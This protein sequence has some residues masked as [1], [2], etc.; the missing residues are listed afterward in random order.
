MRN[1][2]KIKKY[3]NKWMEGLILI[4]GVSLIFLLPPGEEIT[5][6]KVL[7][8]LIL[9]AF[10]V[11]IL[12][13]YFGKFIRKKI[14]LLF[15]LLISIV[16]MGK[17]IILIPSVSNYFIPIAFFSILTSFLFS[18]LPLSILGTLLVSI[19]LSINAGS[20]EI[21]PVL[22]IG[23]L[24]GTYSTSSIHQ[25]T[26]LTRAG[27]YVGMANVC[28]ISGMSFI[29]GYSFLSTL[30]LILWGMGSGILSSV[31]VMVILPYA[32]TYSGITTSIRLLELTDPKFPLLRRLSIESPGTYYH[33]MTV[34]NLAQAAADSI[35]ANSL[36]VKVGS[37]YHDV[38]KIIRPHFFFENYGKNSGKN[39]Y[40]KKVNPNLSSTIIIS[41]VKNGVELA[42]KFRL[43]LSVID[44]IREHHGTGLIAYFYRK[45]L[46]STKKEK[47]VDEGSF[48]YPGPKPQRKESAIVMLADSIEAA[49]RFSPQ[50][51]LKGA[52]DLVRKVIDNKLKDNQLE[53]CNLTLKEITKITRAF[54]SN[55]S[56]I[57]HT[58]G[59]YPT[60]VLKK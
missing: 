32:E 7:G 35:G 45:A 21:L 26:D 28:I 15:F 18:N 43:P 36:L 42:Q 31:M 10:S 4:G 23:G 14:R 6:L 56:G 44:I 29:N 57:I 2:R 33:S 19:L 16:L 40:H 5:F 8:T 12:F 20:P 27:I 41:H 1:T 49:F 11:A 58:R 51:T 55:I 9:I 47:S 13:L 54:K 60:E 46:L 17:V 25:R 59:E 48:R 52:N 38:G 37:Y 30:S 50:I 34:A 3:L 22:L 53:E 24:V 39:D